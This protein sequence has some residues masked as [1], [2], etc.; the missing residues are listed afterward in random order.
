MQHKETI[1]KELNEIAPMLAQIDKKLS[2]SIDQSYLE[3]CQTSTLQKIRLME[4]K[5]EIESV[6]PVLSSIIKPKVFSAYDFNAM[7][8]AVLSKTKQAESA[9]DPTSNWI[10]QWLEKLTA[11]FNPQRSVALAITSTAVLL[12]SVFLYTHSASFY[13]QQL[14]SQLN[15]IPVSDVKNYISYNIDDID[16]KMLMETKNVNVNFESQSLSADDI[17][18]YLEDEDKLDLF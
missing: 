4:Q 17:S 3:A 14:H 8:R 15:Q 2:V 5:S 13:N 16:E 6:A 10:N 18:F 12:I 7:Q 1:L 11:W 9:E